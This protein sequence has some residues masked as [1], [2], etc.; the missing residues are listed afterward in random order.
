F[1]LRMTVPEIVFFRL[2]FMVGYYLLYSW[3]TLRTRSALWTEFYDA[4]LAPSMGF[5]VLRTFCQPFGRGFR[6]TDKTQRPKRIII[7]RRVALPFIVLL[8]LHV[9]G[10]AFALVTGKPIDQPDVF[11]IVVYFTAS[12]LVMLWVCLLV[13]MDIRRARTFPRFA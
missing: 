3:L 6:V 5:T 11:P 10:L 2:P 7:N 1:I 8:L 4:F 13:S 12:N 9:A